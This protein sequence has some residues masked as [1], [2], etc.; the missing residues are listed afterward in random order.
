MEFA[1]VWYSSETRAKSRTKFIVFD[2]VGTLM[3][4]QA[5]LEFRGR[6]HHIEI[7]PVATPLLVAQHL[8][9]V[10]HVIALGVSALIVVPTLAILVQNLWVIGVGLLTLLA[11][12]GA[13]ILLGRTKWILI[14][15]RNPDGT[16][17]NCYFADGSA[18][19]WGGKFGGTRRMFNAIQGVLK[20]ANAAL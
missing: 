5:R 11:V 1:Q 2:D 8:N 17:V 20:K 12:D 19:G 7:A 13:G 16:E 4:E 3:A 10:T 18:L 14:R 9:T 15:G 6:V